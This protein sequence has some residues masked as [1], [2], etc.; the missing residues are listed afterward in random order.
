MHTDLRTRMEW[1]DVM[2]QVFFKLGFTPELIG[3]VIDLK[4]DRAL[5]KILEFEF[6]NTLDNKNS[7]LR[8][9]P[10]RIKE[11]ID[12]P[13]S[14]PAK[15]EVTKKPKAKPKKENSIIGTLLLI[16]LLF[17][18]LGTIGSLIKKANEPKPV[19]DW[20]SKFDSNVE[21][22]YSKP[23]EDHNEQEERIPANS[24]FEWSEEAKSYIKKYRELHP[25]SSFEEDDLFIARK[26]IEAYPEFAKLYFP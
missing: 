10:V 2:N 25:V 20:N 13:K 4:F 11:K 16:V 21:S 23:I 9:Q 3:S 17:S 1:D 24:P 18:A 8:E 7:G 19:Y 26:I 22:T 14:E 5:E 15:V 6:F 12:T